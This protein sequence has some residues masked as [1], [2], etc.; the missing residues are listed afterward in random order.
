M[1]AL[2]ENAEALLETYLGKRTGTRVLGGEI[3]RGDGDEIE[4]AILF[5]DLRGS[6]AL[7]ESVEPSVF[8]AFTN[9]YFSVS[10]TLPTMYYPTV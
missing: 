10:G 9:E 1:F 6:T 2:K 5:C 3:R 4:A 8:V 7:A